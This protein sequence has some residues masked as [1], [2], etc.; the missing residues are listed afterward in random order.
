MKQLEEFIEKDKLA[1]SDE[2]F[3]RI[4]RGIE[5][6]KQSRMPVFVTKGVQFCLVLTAVLL[7]VNVLTSNKEVSMQTGLQESEGF[8]AFAKENYFDILSDYYPQFLVG[9]EI[10]K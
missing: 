3:D 7:M 9:E 6:E 5:R 2:M 8:K 10:E 1:V 4:C